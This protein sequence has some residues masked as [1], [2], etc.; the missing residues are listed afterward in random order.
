M[1]A[2]RRSLPGDFLLDPVILVALALLLVNDHYLKAQWGNW[3]TGKLSDAAG[4]TLFPALLVALAELSRRMLTPT[5]W[6]IRPPGFWLGAAVTGATFVVIKA[7]PAATA[8]S[9]SLN[10]WAAAP[11]RAI[12]LVDSITIRQDSSDLLAVPFVLLAVW[13]GYRWRSAS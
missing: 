2:K 13:V 8:V 9:Q 4:M 6:R 3:W 7:L 12:G 11:L 5:A 1:R 10:Q